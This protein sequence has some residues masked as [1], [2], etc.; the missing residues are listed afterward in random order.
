MRNALLFFNVQNRK[1]KLEEIPSRRAI[2]Y[3]FATKNYYCLI[4][5]FFCF[6]R[7]FQIQIDSGRSY[8]A[9]RVSHWWGTFYFPDVSRFFRSEMPSK[10]ERRINETFDTR[11][12]WETWLVFTF[13]QPGNYFFSTIEHVMR[14][15]CQYV[16][17][18]S[19]RPIIKKK[20]IYNKNILREFDW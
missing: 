16:Y 17:R 7:K 8:D 10:T 20:N 15:Y 14:A 12:F 18:D 13:P 4:P 9:H 6:R 2:I 11:P 1:G 3:R 5:L 19:R